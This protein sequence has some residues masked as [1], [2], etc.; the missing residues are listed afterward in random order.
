[1]EIIL[2]AAILAASSMVLFS[3]FSLGDRQGTQ[4]VA[5]QQAMLLCQSL[6]DELV[7][8]PDKLLPAE[9]VA[10]PAAPEWAYWIQSTPTG[11]DGLMA[12]TVRVAKGT[13]VPAGTSATVPAQPGERTPVVAATPA[14]SIPASSTTAGSGTQLAGTSAAARSGPECTI[15]RWIRASATNADSQASPAGRSGSDAATFSPPS[16][17]GSQP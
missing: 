3:T 16:F 7:A 6:V 13:A 17:L 4:A 2:S 10:F 9:G 1:M 8:R 11:V 12:V 5:D 14:S 15:V